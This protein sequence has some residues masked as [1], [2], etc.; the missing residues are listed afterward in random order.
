[1]KINIVCFPV[2]KYLC[3]QKW[4]CDWRVSGKQNFSYAKP[5]QQAAAFSR[6]S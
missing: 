4:H 5:D 6:I 2:E 1:M 3:W